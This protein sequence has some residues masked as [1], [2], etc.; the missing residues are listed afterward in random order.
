M[1]I[2]VVYEGGF[3]C[4]AVHGPSSAILP[5]DAPKDNLGR[6][7]AYSPT[8]LTATSL[9]TC[10]LTTMA[11]VAQKKGLSADVT[12]ASGTVRKYMTEVPP[13]RIAKLEVDL[14]IPLEEGHPDRAVL[15]QAAIN[16]PVALSLHPEVEKVMRFHWR[17]K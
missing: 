5:T 13:R 14:T 7:E 17:Q 11:I 15:E 16:C 2:S 12:T 8:D 6:G 10:M 3:R 4:Q 1:E 9:I